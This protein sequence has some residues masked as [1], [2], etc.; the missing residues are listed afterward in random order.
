MKEIKFKIWYDDQPNE[1]VDRIALQ[2]QSFGLE[3]IELDG[4]DG[5]IEYEIKPLK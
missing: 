1:V 3:I 4:G 5:F 2:L